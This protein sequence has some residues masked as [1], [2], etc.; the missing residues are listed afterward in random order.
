MRNKP[1]GVA[2]TYEKNYNL[3]ET[4][5]SEKKYEQE[6]FQACLNLVDKLEM[7]RDTDECAMTIVQAIKDFYQADWVGILDVDL[8]MKLWR[9]TWWISEILGRYGKTLFD[10]YVGT[11]LFA[12]WQDVM[13]QGFPFIV[14]EIESLRDEKPE[15]YEFLKTNLLECAIAFPFKRE[16]TGLILVR[17]PKRYLHEVSLLKLLKNDIDSLLSQK[18]RQDLMRNRLKQV[19]SG[20]EEL[21]VVHL[22]GRP[23]L[24]V[25]GTIINTDYLEAPTVW[26]AIY[27]MS[28]TCKKVVTAKEMADSIFSLKLNIRNTADCIRDGFH[29]IN[30][31]FKTVYGEDL[32]LQKSRRTGFELNPKVNII[33][34]C[35]QFMQ[36]REMADQAVSPYEK[37]EYWMKA[38]DL[39]RGDLFHGSANRPKHQSDTN[40]YHNIFLEIMEKL[41]RLLI[42]TK[43]YA[44][45]QIYAVKAMEIEQAYPLFYGIAFVASYMQHCKSRSKSFYYSAK[46]L[47]DDNEFVEVEQIINQY[48]PDEN[49][50]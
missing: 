49:L 14:D 31:G 20:D 36:Y 3:E 24:E 38:I 23:C 42:D 26:E 27:Y 25:R 41:L 44:K 46:E 10:P 9:V 39:Y 50:L 15:E 7:I 11:E 12:D 40:M 48:M 45:A 33:Y 28:E 16:Q 30:D 2:L 17:N 47:M 21:V 37:M 6:A 32:L 19:E 34:D 43:C 29:V 13:E 8:N 5:M 4:M 35:E 18:K 22:F 1:L